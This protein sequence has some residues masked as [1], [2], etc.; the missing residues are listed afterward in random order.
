MEKSILMCT[1]TAAL[2]I[3]TV[4]CTVLDSSWEI[5]LKDGKP[6]LATSCLDARDCDRQAFKACAGRSGF[7][8]YDESLTPGR[9][10]HESLVENERGQPTIEWH[11]R[12]LAD[13]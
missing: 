10:G 9:R 4:G 2:L 13:A 1:A 3:A 5:T 8:K 6:G 11:F 7:I 12:C